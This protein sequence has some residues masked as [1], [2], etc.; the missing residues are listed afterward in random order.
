MSKT[1]RSKTAVIAWREYLAAV[2]TKGFIIGIILMPLLMG[3]GLVLQGVTQ[4]IVD[5]TPRVCEVLDRTPGEQLLPLLQK[6]ADDYNVN[7][8]TDPATHQRVK[9][10]MEFRR[11][12]PP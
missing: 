8:A 6:A 11:V 5:L 7:R 4:N 9:P 10:P 1:P 2:R 3:G 12:P